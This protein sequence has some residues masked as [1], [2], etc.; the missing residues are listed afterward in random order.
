MDKLKISEKYQYL[1]VDFHPDKLTSGLLV[2][3][4]TLATWC[5]YTVCSNQPS[6]CVV[7]DLELLEDDLVLLRIDGRQFGPGPL[8]AGAER[9]WTLT[10]EKT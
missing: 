3:S 4:Y 7:V 1:Q 10:C 8:S 9:L 2:L 5:K 6:T